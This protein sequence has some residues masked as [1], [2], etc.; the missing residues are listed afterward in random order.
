MA[1]GWENPPQ[2]GKLSKIA[3]SIKVGHNVAVV[4]ENQTPQ[5]MRLPGQLSEHR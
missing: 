1:G 2:T 4:T 5:E 3:L